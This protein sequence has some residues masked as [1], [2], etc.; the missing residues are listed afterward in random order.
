MA[1]GKHQ[2]YMELVAYHIYHLVQRSQV[3]L[4]REVTP[5]MVAK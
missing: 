3:I 4:W 1:H 5:D 2:C